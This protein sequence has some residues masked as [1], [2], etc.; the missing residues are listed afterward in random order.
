MSGPA[1]TELRTPIFKDGLPGWLTGYDT[2]ISDGDF[3]DIE[4]EDGRQ[5]F[6]RLPDYG[7]RITPRETQT[8]K[9]AA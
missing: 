8:Q 7:G 6:V 5:T 3:A 1:P 2:T 9:V 4:M